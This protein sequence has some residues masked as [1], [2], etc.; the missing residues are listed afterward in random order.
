MN[1]SYTETAQETCFLI[2]MVIFNYFLW[3]VAKTLMS[4]SK[5]TVLSYLQNPIG[6]L[7]F[8][9]L[10]DLCISDSDCTIISLCS[11]ADSWD[12]AF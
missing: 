7:T 6:S 10:V 1:S 4:I 12:D 11:K 8:V 2:G 9:I 3:F 5:H